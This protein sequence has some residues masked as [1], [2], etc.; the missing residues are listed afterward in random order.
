MKLLKHSGELIFL[1]GLFFISLFMIG[2]ALSW[3]GFDEAYDSYAQQ[4]SRN[5]QDLSYVTIV[6]EVTVTNTIPSGEVKSL[7]D[8][9]NR[10]K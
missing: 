3:K 6:E 9:L 1:S 2:A 8:L 10:V 4:N 7:D 5:G